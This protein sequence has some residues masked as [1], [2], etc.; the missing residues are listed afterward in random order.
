VSA[1]RDRAE[2]WI[3]Q[4][5]IKQA[6][7]L[8]L[9][10]LT[11]EEGN[12]TNGSRGIALT[13]NDLGNIYR[14]TGRASLAE[15]AW[16]RSLAISEAV[17]GPH[18]PDVAVLLLSLGDLKSFQR[19][20]REA[21]SLL[22][23]AQAILELKAPTDPRLGA[24]LCF[25]ATNY[26]DQRRFDKS[27]VKFEQALTILAGSEGPGY[28]EVAVAIC[29]NRRARSLTAQKRYV[30]A[31][32]DFRRAQSITEKHLGSEHLS[33]LRNLSDYAALLRRMKRPAE[34]ALIEHR[35]KEAKA[36][37]GFSQHTVDW[38]EIIRK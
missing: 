35:V 36:R 34:A 10:V 30:E 14:T 18:H 3:R 22:L 20:F 19:Q 15:N 1:S 23:R 28:S 11:R 37:N 2:V 17:S 16:R 38:H 13:L 24:A 21:E 32:A 29:L 33:T 7:R 27:G 26:A 31:E 12:T 5:K 25:L 8:L 4:G 6:E 9:E